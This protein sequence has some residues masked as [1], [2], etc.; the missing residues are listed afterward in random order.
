MPVGGLQDGLR[1]RQHN[2]H[3][4]VSVSLACEAASLPVAWPLYLPKEWADDAERRT[5]AVVPE[6]VEF[7]TKTAMALSQIKHLANQDAK[8][9]FVLADAGYRVRTAFREGLG[10][11][12]LRYVVGVTRAVTVWPPQREP[13]IVLGD[14]PSHVEKLYTK[15][16]EFSGSA[17]R[18]NAWRR[19]DRI[20]VAFQARPGR[21]NGAT[22]S[23]AALPTAA[24]INPPH[25]RPPPPRTPPAR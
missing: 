21:F 20:A 15:H 6:T 5:M 9:H 10:N 12:G 25:R 24:G 23:T 14:A 17:R 13:C 4:A 1:G 18:D 16:A 3:V 8:E 7:A 22:P 19:L 11:F 2:C